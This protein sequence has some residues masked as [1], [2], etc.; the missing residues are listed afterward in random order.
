M[1]EYGM[2]FGTTEGQAV[3]KFLA[4]PIGSAQELFVVVS[5]DDLHPTGW[6]IQTA[7]AR[8]FRR[9]GHDYE[10]TDLDFH[11]VEGSGEC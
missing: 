5:L 1:I 8:L 10:P 11:S 6:E 9:D 7:A 4:Y 3:R 2:S